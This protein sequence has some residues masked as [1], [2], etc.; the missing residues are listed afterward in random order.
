MRERSS[1]FLALHSHPLIYGETSPQKVTWQFMMCTY[2]SQPLQ[3]WLCFY[4]QFQGFFGTTLHTWSWEKSE[5]PAAYIVL[6]GKNPL[7]KQRQRVTHRWRWCEQTPPIEIV[8][9]YYLMC[10]DCTKRIHT[11]QN[12]NNCLQSLHYHTP[13]YT[14]TVSGAQ[15]EKHPFDERKKGRILS[16]LHFDDRN[17][18]PH[19]SGF[20]KETCTKNPTKN[21]FMNRCVNN[22]IDGLFLKGFPAVD[23][24]WGFTVRIF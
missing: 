1:L 10:K 8:R 12:D 2:S 7:S 17:P 5:I 15:L 14:H 24:S 22:T 6:S 20:V 4:L 9:S 11:Y 23:R 3:S 16:L 13:R 21:L 19:T 18:P